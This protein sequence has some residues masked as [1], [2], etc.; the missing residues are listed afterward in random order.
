MS[1]RFSFASLFKK[2][3]PLSTPTPPEPSE[4]YSPEELVVY[5][6]C[7]AVANRLGFRE[8]TTM[9]LPAAAIVMIEVS[10]FI[11]PEQTDFLRK[12]FR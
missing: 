12:Y 1:D 2:D 5:E 9:P 4:I 11:A 3:K 7:Q 10:G 6:K 8:F